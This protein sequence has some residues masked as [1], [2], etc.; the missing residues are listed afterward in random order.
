[1]TFQI[2]RCSKSWRNGNARSSHPGEEKVEE[3]KK[4]VDKHLEMK[5]KDSAH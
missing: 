3:N 4:Q 5:E 2:G 1:M